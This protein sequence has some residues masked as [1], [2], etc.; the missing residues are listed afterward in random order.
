[1]QAGTAQ[2][3]NIQ[4]N[5]APKIEPEG[6]AVV[7]AASAL[8]DTNSLEQPQQDCSPHGKGGQLERQFYAR[9][10]GLFRHGLEIEDPLAL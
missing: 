1:M 9:V 6:E 8:D 7:L 4:I 2:R 5:G 10:P 3:I